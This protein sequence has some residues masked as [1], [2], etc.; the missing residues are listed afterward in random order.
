[1][2]TKLTDCGK[3]LTI[4]S[5]VRENDG[6]HCRE[7]KI[8][9][10]EFDQYKLELLSVDNLPPGEKT[11]LVFSCDQLVEHGFEIQ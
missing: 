11:H 10:A 5:H 8:I 9:E 6:S 2:W 4:H 1:M 7:Y 3:Q